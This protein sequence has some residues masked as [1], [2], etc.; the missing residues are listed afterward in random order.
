[1][2]EYRPASGLGET[3]LAWLQA[4]HHFCFAGY[5]DVER[6]EWGR[7]RY[8]NHDVLAGGAELQ[9]SFHFAVEMLVIV[10]EGEIRI[11]R[12]SDRD[13]VIGR[14]RFAYVAAGTGAEFGIANRSPKPASFTTVGLSSFADEPAA[15]RE[16][17]ALP[18][19]PDWLA[20]GENDDVAPLRLRTL[21][22]VRWL[23]VA[24]GQ[25]IDVRL[26]SEFVYL[27]VMAGKVVIG[28]HRM[29]RHE[30]LAIQ[31]EASL[32]VAAETPASLMLIE[33]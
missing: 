5:Q 8:L 21:A 2:I 11:T 10:D 18:A 9:P 29:T 27:V 22:R 23:D 12:P 32:A 33:G 17:L 30:G 1:M 31:N 20:S 7:T 3:D 26:A 15:F 14:N 19:V 16:S 13:M 24:A 4:R 6:L 25:A 28:R